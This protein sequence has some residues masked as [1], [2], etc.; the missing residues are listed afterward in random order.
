MS[1]EPQATGKAY[2]AFLLGLDDVIGAH[3]TAMLLRR[4]GIAQYIGNY[5]P[6]TEERNGYLLRY[7]SRVTQELFDIYGARGARAI[8]QRVGRAQASRGL[9]ESAALVSV[10]RAAMKLMPLQ[11][12]VTMVL[13]RAGRALQDQ[14]DVVVRATRDHD[15]FYVEIQH[16]PYCVDWKNDTPVCFAMIGFLHRVLQ[17]ATGGSETIEEVEC[18]AK[19]A[20]A[21]RYRITLNPE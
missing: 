16:C 14:I 3:G 12:R 9:E 11:Q 19:G 18:C 8:V 17:R 4:G 6:N 1:G 10:A 15:L 21:C 7:F 5:P 13:E 2:R 20:A